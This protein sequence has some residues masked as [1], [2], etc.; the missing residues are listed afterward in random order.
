MEIPHE[1]STE[2]LCDNR[3]KGVVR[4]REREKGRERKKEKNILYSLFKIRL[5]PVT[6]FVDV[7][8]LNAFS[9]K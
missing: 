8:L 5:V 1:D 6:A 9:A 3:R 7:D 4:E 2:C